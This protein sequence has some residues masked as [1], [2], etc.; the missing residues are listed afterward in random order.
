MKVLI[1][2]ST[3]LVGKAIVAQCKKQAISV[4][5]LTTSKNNIETT[6][7]YK[8]FYW[9][10]NKQEIDSSCFN[11][12]DAII[13]LA[14]ASISNRWTK[15]YKQKILDSRLQ[16]LQLL[17][18][19]I[20]KDNIKIKHIISASAIGIYPD[21]LTNYYEE[22][23]QGHSSSFLGEVTT[24][25]E[26]ATDSFLELG[27]LV[28]KIRIGIVLDNQEGALPQIMKPIN[29]G[30]GAAL[31]SGLQ[32]QSW[33]HKEDLARIF[34][35][36][37]ENKLEGVYNAV[38]SNPVTNQELTK[39]IANTINKPLWLPNIPKVFM[40]L[41]LGEMHVLLFESQRVCSKKI[42]DTGFEF[43]FVNLKPTLE[44]LL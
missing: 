20:K 5:Y 31:G 30:L 1:T 22:N 25:W 6:E 14:G 12:V 3:G 37:L 16:S 24:Q 41:I 9:N 17:K 29:F 38:A 33:I 28:T 8:G 23:Y 10:P 19:T 4:H 36:T 21:S 44:D 15:A 2:G 32:W 39:V 35:Y 18:S 27:I 7:H 11:G 40:S 26:K 43:R 13:N 34:V 42:I